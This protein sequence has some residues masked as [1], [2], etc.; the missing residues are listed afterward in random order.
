M[1]SEHHRENTPNDTM[2]RVVF[3]S[4]DG[5]QLSANAISVTWMEGTGWKG[6]KHA[7]LVR[8]GEVAE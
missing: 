1:S 7:A 4:G 8:E 6:L 2:I 5:K 3:Q